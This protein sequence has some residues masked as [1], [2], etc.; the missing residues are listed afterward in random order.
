MASL[1]SNDN[2]IK[3]LILFVK[4]W[5]KARWFLWSPISNGIPSTM[6]VSPQARL[7][8]KIPLLM[9]PYTIIYI[10]AYS[11]GVAIYPTP[12]EIPIKHLVLFVKG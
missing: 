4:V 12:N 3:H 7:R 10:E 11:L 2:P 6:L 1:L 9:N 5:A 8:E